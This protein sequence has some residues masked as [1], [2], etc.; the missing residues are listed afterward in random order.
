MLA[1]LSGDVNK[2]LGSLRNVRPKGKVKFVSGIRI[3]QVGAQNRDTMQEDCRVVVVV[4][5]IYVMA[6]S[7]WQLH[8]ASDSLPVRIKDDKSWFT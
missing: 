3:A 5:A 8:S 6:I 4:Q 1:T 2:V 7:R